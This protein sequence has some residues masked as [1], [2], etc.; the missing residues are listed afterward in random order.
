MAFTRMASKF[1]DSSFHHNRPTRGSSPTSG[2]SHSMNLPLTP[3]CPSMNSA[4]MCRV[5]SATA[6]SSTRYIREV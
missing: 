5:L 6:V 1:P 2:V 4:G 3:R